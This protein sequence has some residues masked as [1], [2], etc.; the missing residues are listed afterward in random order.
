[1]TENT[2]TSQVNNSKTIHRTPLVPAIYPAKATYTGGDYY[3]PATWSPEKYPDWSKIEIRFATYWVV[4][5]IVVEAFNTVIIPAT[6]Y[7]HEG[8]PLTNTTVYYQFDNNKTR[9]AAT[10]NSE[11]SVFVSFT[12]DVVEDKSI[13]FSY[14]GIPRYAP[15]KYTAPITI[16]KLTPN[17]VV[18]DY[19]FYVGEVFNIEAYLR[20]NNLPLEGKVLSMIIDMDED[21]RRTATTNN[22]GKMTFTE[23]QINSTGVYPTTISYTPSTEKVDGI[24]DSDN[25]QPTSITF[26]IEIKAQVTPNITITAPTYTAGET[27]NITITI[28]N[29]DN[30]AIGGATPIVYI[31]SVRVTFPPTNSSGQSTTA[32]TPTKGGDKN[33]T[34]TFGNTK[35][36]ETTATSKITVNR[37]NTTLTATTP[38]LTKYGNNTTTT[39]TLK[40]A[41]NN[42]LANNKITLLDQYQTTRVTGTT[43]SSGQCTLSWKPPNIGDNH[44]TIQSTQTDT[45]KQATTTINAVIDKIDTNITASNVTVFQ[46]ETA[47]LIITLTDENDIPLANKTITVNESGTTLTTL[48][49]PTDGTITYNHTSTTPTTHTLTLNFAGD[50]NY[51]TKSKNVTVTYNRRTTRLTLYNKAPDEGANWRW[52]NKNDPTRGIVGNAFLEI[53]VLAQLV[54]TTTPTDDNNYKQLKNKPITIQETNNG[55]TTTTTATTDENG[56]VAYITT[57][58]LNDL[59]KIQFIFDGDNTYTTSQT[60]NMD[61]KFQRTPAIFYR[62]NNSIFEPYATLALNVRCIYI[63]SSGDEVPVTGVPLKFTNNPAKYGVSDIDD[64]PSEGV[65][66]TATTNSSGV[67]VASYKWTSNLNA[68]AVFTAYKF[69]EDNTHLHFNTNLMYT[70]SRDEAITI[71]GAN[72]AQYHYKADYTYA[73]RDKNGVVSYTSLKGDNENKWVGVPYGVICVPKMFMLTAN[74]VVTVKYR[75]ISKDTGYAFMIGIAPSIGKWSQSPAYFKYDNSDKSSYVNNRNIGVNHVTNT[76]YTFKMVIDGA[77]VKSI[78]VGG[79]KTSFNI[80]IYDMFSGASSPKL[81]LFTTGGANEDTLLVIESV[82]LDID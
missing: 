79:V 65:W 9:T 32:Y 23:N 22:N 78:T 25:Y 61:C 63:N 43:N 66:A 29:P 20:N 56:L 42:P 37:I 10:T 76:T 15:S 55:Q 26:P 35:Y 5:A 36:K 34:A 30:T 51:K 48:R 49:T 77:E 80:D 21:S 45:H 68:V 8:V 54:D 73:K 81:F 64:V 44:Y 2:W 28:K 27:K 59:H 24:R 75:I 19:S 11:G 74:C 70:L 71:S 38:P 13:T 50:T 33:I 40:D 58:Q 3:G 14:D 17:I 69:A 47:T 12:A 60:A 67:A 18:D 57:G 4:E 62:H 6:L 72:I 53:G 39:V 41:S 52:V 31:D 1:M 16:L 46:D 7:N 82:T